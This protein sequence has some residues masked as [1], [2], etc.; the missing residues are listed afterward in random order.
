VEAYSDLGEKTF[1]SSRAEKVGRSQPRLD[2]EAK[3]ELEQIFG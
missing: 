1:A 3:E 2:I